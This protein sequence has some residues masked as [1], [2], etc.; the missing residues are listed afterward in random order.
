MHPIT[1]LTFNEVEHAQPLK[2]RLEQAGI[3]AQIHDDRK[4][5]KYYFMSPPLAC[6]RVR[7]D[8]SQ[9]QRARELLQEWDHK[10]HLLEHAIHCP[11]CGSSRVQFPQFSRKVIISWLGALACAVGLM[12]REFYC[13]DCHLTWPTSVTIPQAKDELGWPMKRAHSHRR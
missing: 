9:W 11:E 1:V 2:E 4:L 8:R 5:E 12:K 6:I 7:V 3:P 10:E 13:Q